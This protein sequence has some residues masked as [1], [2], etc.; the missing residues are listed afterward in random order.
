MAQSVFPVKTS[1]D[2]GLLFG[3]AVFFPI[4]L[5]IGLIV[6]LFGEANYIRSMQ[7]WVDHSNDVLIQAQQLKEYGLT[8]QWDYRYYR[9]TGKEEFL[10]KSQ[11]NDRLFESAYKRLVNLVSDNPVQTENVKALYEIAQNWRNSRPNENASRGQLMS[12]ADEFVNAERVLRTERAKRTR[13][14]A[15]ILLFTVGPCALLFVIIVVGYGRRALIRVSRT[16]Q[17]AL[18]ARDEFLSIAS[19]ELKTPLTALKLQLQMVERFIRDGSE[20]DKYAKGLTS[21]LRQV[22]SLARL[23]DELLDVSRIQTGRLS[24]AFEEV[25]VSQLVSDIVERYEDQLREGKCPLEVDVSSGIVARWDR[26]RMEQVL[27]NL[28]GNIV[29]YAPGS[30]AR[31]SA[32]QRGEEVIINVQDSGPGIPKGDQERIFSRFERAASSQNISG[33]GLGLYV[34]KRIIGLHKG[35]IRVESA[36]GQGTKF[37]I[38]M[39]VNAG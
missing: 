13:R 10:R 37:I 23:V 19:H 22:N 32:E 2:L 20:L 33:L 34:V 31:I 25:N 18:Q 15:A 14:L 3:R 30:H 36:P 4:V 24:L 27:V 6:V 1:P 5:A 29:K 9:L 21:S 8:A 28:I 38:E 11:E 17:S 12:A 7:G 39:P 35:S 16:Y 26:F